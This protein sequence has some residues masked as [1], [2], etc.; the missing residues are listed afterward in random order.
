MNNKRYRKILTKI[1]VRYDTVYLRALKIRRDG[2][3][4]LYARQ[5]R[6]NKDKLRTMK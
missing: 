1:I 4:S 5:K 6:K 2:Q 3:L